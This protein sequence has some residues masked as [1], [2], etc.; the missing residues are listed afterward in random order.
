M[1]L[2]QIEYSV[3]INCALMI[4]MHYRKDKG[5]FVNKPFINWRNLQEKA[6]RHEQIK[7]RRD[8]MIATASLASVQTSP[9]RR[10]HAG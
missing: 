3:N 7:Y 8:A 4:P 1:A 5:A 2:Q 6:K 9:R 10:L